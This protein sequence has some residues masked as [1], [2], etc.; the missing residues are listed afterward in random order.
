MPDSRDIAP[1]RA[2]AFALLE[3]ALGLSGCQRAPE[4]PPT[5]PVRGRIEFVRGGPVQKIWDRQG[6]IQFQSVEQP[7]VYAFGQINED[8]SFTLA[9]MKG[10]DGWEGAIAGK[11]R[12]RLNLDEDVQH[13]VAPKFLDYKKSGIEITVPTEGEVVIKVSK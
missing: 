12:G 4:P 1:R 2:A 11:H 9:T 6:A 3:L 10:T 7:D 8:G 5:F 13:L